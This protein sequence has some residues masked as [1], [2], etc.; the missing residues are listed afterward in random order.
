MSVAVQVFILELAL[1]PLVLVVVP[2]VVLP[3]LAILVLVLCLIDTLAVLLLP[4][5][6]VLLVPGRVLLRRMGIAIKLLPILLLVQRV[7][8]DIVA[9]LELGLTVAPNRFVKILIILLSVLIVM[10]LIHALVV[11]TL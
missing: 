11:S 2:H 6:H 4:I 9:V 5:V 3:L 8:L 1:V 7:L 10:L